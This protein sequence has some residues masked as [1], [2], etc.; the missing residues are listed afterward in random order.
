ML[1]VPALWLIVAVEDEIRSCLL[2]F[3]FDLHVLLALRIVCL[4]RLLMT[5]HSA[6]DLELG[7]MDFLATEGCSEYAHGG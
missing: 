4:V 6:V 1:E 7:R 3:L 5:R 2:N